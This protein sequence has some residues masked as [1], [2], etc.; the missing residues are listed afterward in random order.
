MELGGAART[1]I[2]V[3]VK[4]VESS[5]S[6]STAPLTGEEARR[7]R[8]VEWGACEVWMESIYNICIYVC[9]SLCVCV[10]VVCVRQGTSA[11]AGAALIK[12]ILALPAWQDQN[13][14]C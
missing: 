5:A 14:I 10:C 12:Q 3:F 4:A 2:K 7:L 13:L 8:S 11:R 6:G 1:S 9:V